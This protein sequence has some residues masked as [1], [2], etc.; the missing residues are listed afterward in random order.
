MTPPMM[1]P[2]MIGQRLRPTVRK[3]VAEIVSV[4]KNSARLTEPI[5]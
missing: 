2:A 1:R 4:T 3:N 5:A